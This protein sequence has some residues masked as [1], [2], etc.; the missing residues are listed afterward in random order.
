MT[1]DDHKELLEVL[2]MHKGPVV[3]S[4]YETELYNDMLCGWRKF[5]ATSYSQV[6]SK[7]KEVVWMNYNPPT[8]Q[9]TIEDYFMR[10]GQR[11]AVLKW[12]HGQRGYVSDK[13]GFIDDGFGGNN[14]FVIL[15]CKIL[16]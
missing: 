6:H 12:I 10:G 8:K 2:L 7:K 9:M 1:A 15:D 5:E 13:R 16:P 4:G 3:I 14:S 11:W